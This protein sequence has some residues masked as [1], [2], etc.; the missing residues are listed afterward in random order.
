MNRDHVRPI[1]SQFFSKQTM[2]NLCSPFTALVL[3][4]VF[5]SGVVKADDDDR[6][7]LPG[8]VR[9]VST[10]PSNGDVN[11]YGVAFVPPGFPSDGT[12]HPGDVLVSNFNASS[13][14]QGSGTTIVDVPT[15]RQWRSSSRERPRWA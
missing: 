9:V 2:L 12:I 13:N 10:V 14:L 8:P 1:H 7:F 5:S 3:L 6:P 4:C 11:P 15:Q